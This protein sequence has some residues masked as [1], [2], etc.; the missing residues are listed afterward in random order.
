MRPVAI[1]TWQAEANPRRF[2]PLLARLQVVG[3]TPLAVLLAGRAGWSG[4]PARQVHILEVA[5]SNPAPE[6]LVRKP[7]AGNRA[8]APLP[9]CAAGR[10]VPAPALAF[11]H[12]RDKPA[13]A[14]LDTYARSV[15]RNATLRERMVHVMRSQEKAKV[16]ELTRNWSPQIRAYLAVTGIFSPAPWCAAFVTWCLLEAGAD[17][18]KLPKN[19]ASTYFWWK[20]AKET[21]RLKV[22]EKGAPV[23]EPERGDLFDWNSDGGGHIGGIYDV[24][25]V[26]GIVKMLTIEGNTDQAG[27]REGVAVM[28]RVRMWNSLARHKRYGIIQIPD[29]LGVGA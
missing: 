6:R 4:G 16:R 5:G 7:S 28:N 24:V 29:E 11:S 22:N 1:S 20:W 8:G 25:E 23:Y 13:P 26:K 19:A 3:F 9:L 18:K 27:S 17:R 12:W 21:G 10:P 14:Y 15:W 2:S